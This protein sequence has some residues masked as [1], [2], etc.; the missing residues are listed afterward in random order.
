VVENVSVAYLPQNMPPVLKNI[1]V[2]TQLAAATAGKPAPQ[3]AT[4]VYSIT[5]TD[6]GDAA[7]A[8]SAGTPTQ[9]PSRAASQQI[10]VSWQ[11]EDPDGDRLVYSLWFRGEGEREWKLLKTN[12]HET[13]LSIDGD[14][15]ADGKYFFRV[16]ASDGEV[17]PHSVAKEAELVSS[18]VLIDNTPPVL[19]VAAPRKTASGFAVEFE[20]IDSAS[21]LRRCEYSVDAGTWTPIESLDGVIDSPREK[22]LVRLENLS[23]GE[24][25]LVL[26][27]VDSANNAGLAKVIL[28]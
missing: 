8:L 10:N 20:A 17:N 2:V 25:V 15:L 12:M 23:P 5:V 16:V 1:T 19:S 28:R 18:P 11:A 13:T 21:A 4:A 22:F 9:T 7:P 27:A 24:H 6:T 26:R 3:T 14:A